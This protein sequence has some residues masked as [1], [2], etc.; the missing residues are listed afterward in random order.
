MISAPNRRSSSQSWSSFDPWGPVRYKWATLGTHVTL[1]EVM[2]AALHARAATL[3]LTCGGTRL[4]NDHA[5]QGAVRSCSRGSQAPAPEG[6]S[7]GGSP[8]EQPQCS[9]LCVERQAQ[10]RVK[11]SGVRVRVCD[12]GG[13]AALLHAPSPCF[14]FSF[15]E[16]RKI[17]TVCFRI[18]AG[19]A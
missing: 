6:A 4:G 19:M 13:Q 2:L 3:P 17:R 7:K 10:C 15:R 16:G 5:R 14:S 18:T 1:C 9:T 8:R 12:T 11:P